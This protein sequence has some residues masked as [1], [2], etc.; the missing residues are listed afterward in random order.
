MHFF[1]FVALCPPSTLTPASL[2]LPPPPHPHP[3]RPSFFLLLAFY[4][5]HPQPPSFFLFFL[6]LPFVFRCSH[7][8]PRPSSSVRIIAPSFQRAFFPFSMSALVLRLCCQPSN[9]SLFGVS[10]C[11]SPT[12]TLV[13][14]S[15]PTFALVSFSSST[16]AVVL[17]SSSTFALVLF[18]SPRPQPSSPFSTSAFL[19]FTQR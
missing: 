5:S 9:S 19:C 10:P 6:P 16:F 11:P 4:R 8:S 12:F 18:S 15:L 1:H 2:I 3:S 13:L 7:R 14:F 17:F